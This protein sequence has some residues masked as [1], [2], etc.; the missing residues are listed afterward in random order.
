MP[1]WRTFVEKD[2]LGA[3]DMV[4]KCTKHP[5]DAPEKR[6]EACAKA[7]QPRDY[8]LK[9]A[10]VASVALKTR[11]T[12]KANPNGRR[13]VVIYFERA[14]KAMVGNTTNCETIES[15]FGAETDKW[16]GK[17]ITLYQT[18]VRNPKGGA[19]IKGIRVRPKP[20]TSAP[21]EIKTGPVDEAVRAAQDAAFNRQLGED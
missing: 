20:P 9:I 16:V 12:M 11:E 2:Y 19:M 10:R 17:S 6:C 18:D 4:W 13:K 8:T 15:M 5:V 21:E 7:G 14:D 3:W 1:N